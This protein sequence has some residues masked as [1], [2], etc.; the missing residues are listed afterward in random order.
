TAT[1]LAL[2]LQTIFGFTFQPA[3]EIPSLIFGARLETPPMNTA[4]ENGIRIPSHSIKVR[5]G[6]L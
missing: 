3:N 4:R 2:P 5:L 6:I 1:K